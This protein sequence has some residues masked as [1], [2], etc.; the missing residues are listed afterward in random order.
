MKVRKP[1]SS[2]TTHLMTPTDDLFGELKSLR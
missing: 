2:W 1:R